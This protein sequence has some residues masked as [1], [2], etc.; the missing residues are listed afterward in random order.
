[1]FQ[2]AV[3]IHDCHDHLLDLE[4]QTIWHCSFHGHSTCSSANSR[5]RRSA[6]V[7]TFSWEDGCFIYRSYSSRLVLSSGTTSRAS[8]EAA[9]GIPPPD[10]Q[11]SAVKLYNVRS[12]RICGRLLQSVSRAT[13]ASSLPSQPCGDAVAFDG[14]ASCVTSDKPLIPMH[15]CFGR[16]T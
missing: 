14:T 13:T 8:S 5:T 4:K 9:N 7:R 16:S 15:H 2:G 10:S 11:Y 3:R 1:M 12:A 6:D